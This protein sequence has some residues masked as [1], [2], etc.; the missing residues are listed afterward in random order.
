[1]EGLSA[2]VERSRQLL[3]FG[4]RAHGKARALELELPFVPESARAPQNELQPV[5]RETTSEDIRWR[6]LLGERIRGVLAAERIQRVLRRPGIDAPNGRAARCGRTGAL[7]PPRALRLSVVDDKLISA[8]LEGEPH[9]SARR[10]D[11]HSASPVE[12]ERDAL[13]VH[14]QSVTL[15]R[16]SFAAVRRA[17]SDPR[18]E[19]AVVAERETRRK[20]ER[21]RGEDDAEKAD[22]KSGV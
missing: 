18:P 12:A 1:G 8:K 11:E 6:R 14:H 13:T 17:A 20:N 10:P 21:E 22:R 4:A 19:Q 16:D 15:E 5:A 9:L 2:R 3:A 7:P